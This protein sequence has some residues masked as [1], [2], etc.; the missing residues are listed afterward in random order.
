VAARKTKAESAPAAGTEV[1]RW[2]EELARQAEAAAGMEANAGGGQFFS[3]RGGI[4]TFND[5]QMPDNQMAAVIADAVMENVFYEGEFDAN[6]PSPPLCFAFGRDEATMAPHP[7]VVE[8]GQAQHET[9][10]GCPMN[11]WATADKGRGKACRNTRRL[12]L[13]SAGAF[14]KA[15]NFQA[16]DD[17]ADFQTQ[18][19]GYLKLAVTSV[20]GYAGYV[21][22]MAAVFKRPPFGVFTKVR[23][24]P[25]PKTQIRLFFEPLGLVPTPLLGAISARNKEAAAIIEF[26]YSLDAGEPA[27]A[28]KAN[29]R[30][31]A[32]GG[33]G[34]PAAPVSN[35]PAAKKPAAK[36]PAAAA[37]KY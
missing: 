23:L 35:R 1:M 12:A 25:D 14:D 15:G 11:E 17:P 16:Y 36:K 30:P 34:A 9:C 10:R 24:V 33:R 29:A 13:L 22:Q 31:P 2:D 20:K 32:R 3:T 27:S 7:S 5:V 26:P 18:P 37:K 19:F 6:N 21:K 28:G 4:L 8:A